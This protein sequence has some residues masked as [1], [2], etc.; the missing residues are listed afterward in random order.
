MS[1]K[2]IIHKNTHGKNQNSPP[3]TAKKMKKIPLWPRKDEQVSESN[4]H[5]DT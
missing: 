3:G 4:Q 2:H 5:P 1:K